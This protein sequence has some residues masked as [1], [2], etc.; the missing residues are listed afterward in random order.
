MAKPPTENTFTATEM[1]EIRDRVRGIMANEG[2]SQAEI[3]RQAGVAYGTFTGWLGGTYQ[4]NNDKIAG[5]VQIWL[6]ARE[7]KKRQASRIPETPGFQMTPTS[8]EMLDLLGYAQIFPGI[9]VVAGGAGIGKTR[10]AQHYAAT[11]PNVWIVTMEPCSRT[12]YPM[13]AAIAEQMGI[14]ERVMTKL[15]RA[16]GRKVEGT[17]G[18]LVIDEAQHL[19]SQALDQLRALH[20]LY[21]VGV[22]LLG[23]E[24]VYN[25]LEGEGRSPG[26]AQLFSRIDMRKTQAHPKAGD[27]CALIKS[28]GVE[29]SEEV[30]FLKAIGRKPGALRGLTK[31]LQLATMMAAGAGEERSIQH[32][33][34]AY[35]RLSASGDRS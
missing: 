10:S 6:S 20:D 23:N 33:K 3:A 13:L 35:E 5:E 25:R 14:A 4:G 7:D 19:H 32:L 1:D 21:H 2:M 34:A 9:V 18:L 22:A 24:A 16:I 12:V 17:G 31:C 29:D 27:I 15:S 8:A 11:N 28:W 26:F 30:K